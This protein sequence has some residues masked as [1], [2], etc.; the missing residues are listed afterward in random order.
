MVNSRFF[1]KIKFEFESRHFLFKVYITKNP[2]WFLHK[3]FI[4]QKRIDVWNYQ[5]WSCRNNKFFIRLPAYLLILARSIKIKSVDQ[6][7]SLWIKTPNPKLSRL[8]KS[9]IFMQKTPC[10]R[11]NFKP[12]LV[13]SQDLSFEKSLR[14]SW[15]GKNNPLNIEFDQIKFSFILNEN[16]V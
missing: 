12:F 3:R 11:I 8:K 4:I 13:Y 5:N 6:F 7:F 9:S 16:L 10:Y 14:I 15:K 2:S 1:E